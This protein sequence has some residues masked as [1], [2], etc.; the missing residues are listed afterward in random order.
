MAKELCCTSIQ[1]QAAEIS[2]LWMQEIC[3]P[4]DWRILQ[5]EEKLFR[6]Q[7]NSV[8]RIL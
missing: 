8:C 1:L 7:K 6:G 2:G 5:M 3:L 4:R